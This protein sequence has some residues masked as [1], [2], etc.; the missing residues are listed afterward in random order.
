M[1]SLPSDAAYNRI[2]VQ[3][4]RRQALGAAG[5]L[6]WLPVTTQ[7]DSG[8]ACLDYSALSHTP[9]GGVLSG[10]KVYTRAQVF[11]SG[12]LSVSIRQ[13]Q[14]VSKPPPTPTGPRY[15]RG[16]SSGSARRIRRAL[17]ALGQSQR[18]QF[19]L[20]TF[21]AQGMRS[22]EQMRHSWE[23]FLMWGRKYLPEWFERY[24][25]VAE[26]SQRGVLHFHLVLPKRVPKALFLRM[27]RLW[28]E[29]YGMGPGSVDIEKLHSAKGA[30]SYLGKL[31]RYISK[32]PDHYRLELHDDGYIHYKP[33]RVGRNGLPYV[34]DRFRGRG[35]DMSREMRALTYPL[36][37]FEAPWG[38]FPSLDPRGKPWRVVYLD[39][40]A[41]AHDVLEGLCL[42]RGPDG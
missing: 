34:R 11:P 26:D 9:V 13:T 41:A 15:T 4:P 37:T 3:P 32:S 35:C 39:S 22:D 14:G 27:R 5:C 10:A 23:K 33:W 17:V 7:A 25:W 2:G 31:A 29:K 24:L 28:A 18:C 1:H 8:A 19:V 16:V 36:T 21:T 42:P 30:A 6:E 12:E 40:P 20:L 38:A